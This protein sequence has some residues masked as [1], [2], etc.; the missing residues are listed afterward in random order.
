MT[1]S[2]R[3]VSVDV[4]VHGTASVGATCPKHGKERCFLCDEGYE[5]TT[6]WTCVDAETIDSSDAMPVTRYCNLVWR[7]DKIHFCEGCQNRPA[8]ARRVRK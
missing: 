5:L 3:A 7:R 8:Y 4:H 1:V 2:R 6:D